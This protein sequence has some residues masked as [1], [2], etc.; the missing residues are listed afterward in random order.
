[1]DDPVLHSEREA[2]RNVGKQNYTY[3][4]HMPVSALLQPRVRVSAHVC[5]RTPACPDALLCQTLRASENVCVCV[6][7]FLHRCA[8][9]VGAVRQ[10]SHQAEQSGSIN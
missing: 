1:M 9:T 8:Y 4:N 6:F 5:R 3:L 7:S 2:T 10:Y